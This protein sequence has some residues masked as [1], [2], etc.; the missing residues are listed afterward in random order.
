MGLTDITELKTQQTKKHNNNKQTQVLKL[1]SLKCCICPLCQPVVG[2][3]GRRKLKVPSGE[4]TELKRFPFKAWCRPVFSHT[5]YAYCQG[6][7]PYLFLPFPSIHLH[8]FQNL[9]RFLVC[10]LWLTH[11]SFVGPQNKI[12]HPARVRFPCKVPAECK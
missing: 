9:S 6:F 3:C 12:G 5:C 7:L 11:G 4:N 8:F 2:S 10:W 1:V